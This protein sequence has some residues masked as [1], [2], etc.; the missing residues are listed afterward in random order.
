MLTRVLLLAGSIVFFL[1]TRQPTKST[2]TATLFPSPKLFRSLR[3][4]IAKGIVDRLQGPRA[5]PH[6][7]ERR[8]LLEFGDRPVR[9]RPRLE[10]PR[11]GA[12]PQFGRWPGAAEDR[13]STRLNSSH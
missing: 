12:P 6:P 11:I 3:C 13:K 10:P 8:I 5:R 2:L 1:I 4:G 9:R 7:R